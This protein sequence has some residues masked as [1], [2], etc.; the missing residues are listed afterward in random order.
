MV[1][2]VI[3]MIW[4]VNAAGLWTFSIHWHIITTLM[5]PSD[6]APVETTW[7]KCSD[8]RLGVDNLFKHQA[9]NFKSCSSGF[10]ER[11][12]H[13]SNNRHFPVFNIWAILSR[14]L[15]I[16]KNVQR[17]IPVPATLTPGHSFA[18][19]WPNWSWSPELQYLSCETL[20][21]K[22][23]QSANRNTV[24]YLG[25]SQQPHEPHQV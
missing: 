9:S 5:I 12:C 7:D 21:D 15:R 22:K 18:R 23:G 11:E 17:S 25:T 6:L 10:L 1:G 16:L 20:K 4:N 8:F 3:V 19:P 24:N 2:H 13:I 14:Y